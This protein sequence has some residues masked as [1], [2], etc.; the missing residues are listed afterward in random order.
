MFES[1]M[2][3]LGLRD[4]VMPCR[5]K[6]NR[7]AV[8][9][10]EALR[11]AKDARRKA[12]K[13]R[14]KEESEFIYSYSAEHALSDEKSGIRESRGARLQDMD[15]TLRA[16]IVPLGASDLPEP[17]CPQAD[18][19]PDLHAP[20]L[21][22]SARLLTYV[23]EKCAGIAPTAYKRAGVSRQIYSRIVSKDNS[24]VDKRTAML[25][26]IGLQLSMDEARLL[27]ESAGYAFSGTIPEDVVFSYCIEKQIW[28]LYDVNDVFKKCGLGAAVQTKGL[29]R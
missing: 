21:S 5:M 23:N 10:A 15:G 16:P 29:Y 13:A 2:I 27:M 4:K 19:P 24:T 17:C 8:C 26:C 12:D 6:R 14:R 1:I 9:E 20:V 3:W 11:K 28:N 18:R 25:F 7:L 22:F